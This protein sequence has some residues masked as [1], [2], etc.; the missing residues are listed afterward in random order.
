[1]KTNLPNVEVTSQ[2]WRRYRD[3]VRGEMLPY[4]W[5]VISDAIDIDIPF[6]PAGNSLKLTKSGVIENLRIAAGRAEGSFT[7]FPYADSDAYKWLEAVAYALMSG[8]APEL[9]AHGDELVD[10]IADAQMDDGYLDSYYQINGI[11]ERFTLIGQSHELYNMGHYIEAGIAYWEATGSEKALDV[12]RRMADCIDAN[13][14]PEEGKIHMGD[15]HPEIE[16]ALARLYEATGEQRYLDL[17]HWLIVS[18]GEDPEFY[19]REIAAQGDKILFDTMR[20]LPASYYQADKPYLEQTEVNGHA[21]R[22]LYLLGAAA[23]T[24]RLAGDD[25]L[26]KT[27]ETLWDDV[28]RRRMY[29]TGQV[30]STQIGE[31]FTYDYDLPNDTMYGETC[32]SVALSFVARRMLEAKPRGEYGD[33]L[34]R[35]LFN[36]TISGMALDGCHFY[37]VNPLEADPRATAGNPSKTHVLTH[38]AEWFGTACCPANLARLVSSVDRYIY[39][40]ADGGATVLVNQ[41]I[42]SRAT[43][44]SGV[45]VE[46]EGDYPWDGDVALRASNPTDAPVRVGVRIPA[47][48]KADAVVVVAG[49][50]MDPETVDGF[51]YATVEPGQTLE[52]A[53]KLPMRPRCVRASN[54]VCADAGRVAVMRGPVVYCMESADN[55]GDLWNYQ[56]DCATLTDAWH[57]ELLGGVVQVTAD[58]VRAV[59]DGAD[60]ALYQEAGT[61]SWEPATLSFVPYYAW[62]NRADG[63][64]RVWV[65]PTDPRLS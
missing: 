33:V 20:N 41:Y 40:E 29:V 63:Q 37:Y 6:D 30:G 49:A 54:R 11:D 51:A 19:K 8:D 46:Q 32:A 59:S 3:V 65:R 43:F 2:F 1:M 25:A 7:G 23:H 62:A 35:A 34:E 24:A 47:W 10:L 48:A 14:G 55:D 21:V 12:A 64:M 13:F 27:V 50:D 61:V 57:P 60:D 36:G 16:V 38:R 45:T 4:Q 39:G 9:R 42:A 53:V 22:S 5:N 15:G 18:R 17:G 56:L 52:L 44:A 28:T 58:G 31:A 26:A